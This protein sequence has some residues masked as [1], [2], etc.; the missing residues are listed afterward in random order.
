VCLQTQRENI[1]TRLQTGGCGHYVHE[2]SGLMTN[3]GVF[4]AELGWQKQGEMEA[5]LND[6]NI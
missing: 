1:S 5:K 4:C 6:Y 3:L 2:I